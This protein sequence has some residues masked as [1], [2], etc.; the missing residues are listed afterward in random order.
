MLSVVIVVVIL[1]NYTN[2]G[3]LTFSIIFTK[4]LISY[5][6][7]VISRYRLVFCCLTPF[8]QFCVIIKSGFI[9]LLSF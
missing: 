9:N 2:F 7:S 6:T 3:S 4:R 8:I 1:C 5:C